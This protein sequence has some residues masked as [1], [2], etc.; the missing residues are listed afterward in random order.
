MFKKNIV[1]IIA[2]YNP[3]HNGHLYH[4]DRSLETSGADAVVVVLSSNF[5][6]RGE[7][8]F[9]DKWSRAEMALHSG[10]DLV[11]ELPTAFSCHN[12]GVFGSAAVDLMAMTGIVTHLSFGMED[13]D[14][15]L[16]AIARI[17]VEEP[18]PFR[19]ILRERLDSG[20]SYAEARTAAMEQM[21]PGA[22]RILSSPNNILAQEYVLRIVERG[23]PLETTPVK[24]TGTGYHSGP[25]GSFAGAGWIRDAV[26]AEG[27]SDPVAKVM[28]PHALSSLREEISRGR[29]VLSLDLFW[30]ILRAVLL[31]EGPSGI[32]KYAEMREG[33]ENLLWAN[34][35]KA[36]S[37]E[38]FTSLCTSRRYPGSRIRRSACHSL[39]GYEHQANRKAQRLGPPYI[40]ILGW[41]AKG[42]EILRRMKTSSKLPVLFR[43]KGR[44]GTY[45]R[46]I[47]DLEYRATAL[48]ESL[49]PN[50]EPLSESKKGPLRLV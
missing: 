16:G 20:F 28:P 15:P 41:D 5:V 32:S 24:R 2:E 17:L 36:R 42:Q 11:I 21:L 14:A 12:A 38:E 26:R 46:M 45:Q 23:Y 22:G 8:A 3:I 49:V 27:I 48:W 44:P 10:A 40:R 18:S 13:P 50:P 25:S 4:I 47:A 6:Q 39:I 43:P 29:C 9:L 34:A 19:K 31:R 37:F 30:R 7:P 35:V 33:I 1:G